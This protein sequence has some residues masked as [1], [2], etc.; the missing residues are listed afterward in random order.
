MLVSLSGTP[1]QSAS[2][3]SKLEDAGIAYFE[4]PSRAAA[5]AAMLCEFARRAASS[6]ASE[7]VRGVPLQALPVAG[8]AG[9]LDEHAAKRFLNAYGIAAPRGV[10]IG[11]D[12]AVP[13]HLD[14]KFP[15]AA[16]IVSPD[17]VHK[18]EIGGVMLRIA[19]GE[20]GTVLERLRANVQRA[21]PDARI[22]GFLVEEMAEGTEMIVGALANSAFGPLVMVGMGGVHAEV[23]RDVQRRY[24]PVSLGQAREMILGLKG[25]RLLQ[26]YRG[27]PA[28][29]V[30]ALAECVMRLSWMICDHECDIAEIEINPAMVGETGRDAV[31]V[32]AVIRL[33]AG[34]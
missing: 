8:C 7:V 2:W 22:S 24:A 15:V 20:L 3:S 10:F 4:V 21:A 25:A 26:R 17:I 31:A 29:D 34:G 1:G 19:E 16:K 6:T 14:L 33:K 27:A 9:G 12:E 5:A 30:E 13:V 18:T 32:D 23:L 28:R 11:A